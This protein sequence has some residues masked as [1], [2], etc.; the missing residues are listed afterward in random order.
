LLKNKNPPLF[1]YFLSGKKIPLFVLLK[2]KNPP[3]FFYHFII[4]GGFKSGGWWN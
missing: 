1:L 3:L 4:S 2:N